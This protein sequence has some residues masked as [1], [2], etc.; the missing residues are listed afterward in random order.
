[1]SQWSPETDRY[2]ASHYSADALAGKRIC[3]QDLV[4]QFGLPATAMDRPLLGV[5]SRLTSQKGTELLLEIVADLAADDVYLVVLG[6]GDA[7]YETGL[8]EAAAAN[9][10]HIAVRI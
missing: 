6:S 4:K 9:P 1:Y 3:K 8:R 10:E 5:V 7:D 2:L